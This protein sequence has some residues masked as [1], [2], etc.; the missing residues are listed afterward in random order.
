MFGL[1]GFKLSQVLE[2]WIEKLEKKYLLHLNDFFLNQV[3]YAA[4]KAFRL[5]TAFSTKEIN[6]EIFSWLEESKTK[7][8]FAKNIEIAIAENVLED[9][10]EIQ[11]SGLYEAIIL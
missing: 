8:A 4:Y 7:S 10:N 2:K 9:F 1:A 3:D 11:L 5:K 6:A